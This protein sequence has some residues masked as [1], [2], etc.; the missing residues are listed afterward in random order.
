MFVAVG[1]GVSWRVW[2]VGCVQSGLACRVWPV[3]AVLA[4]VCWGLW[5]L[6]CG[7]CP[8]V[9]ALSC[10]SCRVCPVV[11]VLSFLSCRFRS[12][13]AFRFF[14]VLSLTC[15]CVLSIPSVHAFT[16]FYSPFLIYVADSTLSDPSP[17]PYYPVLLAA[18]L[19]LFVSST[20]VSSHA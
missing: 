3:V 16:T 1:S 7:V 10:L 9:S 8:V 4:W 6:S 15:V 13:R 14:A 2:V 19:P 12:C 5:G 18:C 17:L 11:S 20:I